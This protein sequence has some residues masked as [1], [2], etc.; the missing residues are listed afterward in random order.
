M[1][2]GHSRLFGVKSIFLILVHFLAGTCFKKVALFSWFL[3]PVLFYDKVFLLTFSSIREKVPGKSK[4]R[5]ART[6]FWWGNASRK[7]KER[8]KD[9]SGIVILVAI[10]ILIFLGLAHRVLDQ[11]YLSDRSGLIFIGALIAGSFIDFTI[12][13]NPAVTLN[14][15]GGILPVALAIYVLTKAG[16]GKEWLRSIIGVVLTVGVLYGVNRLYRFDTASGFIDPQFLWAIIAGVIAYIVGRSRR[17][18]FIIAT[19]GI[20]SLDIVHIITMAN[21]GLNVPT[22]IGGGGVFDTIVIAGILAVLLAE[23]IGESREALQGGPAKEGRPD[24][25]VEALDHPSIEK[26]GNER[27][28]EQ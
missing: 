15:G 28:K 12:W 17:L 23:I 26:N 4:G 21:R 14:L 9:M 19:L 8:L 5:V 11:L 16:S 6:L 7:W 20:L 3:K 10:S 25:L 24:E 2:F 13:R 27:G 1:F 22:R 18:S